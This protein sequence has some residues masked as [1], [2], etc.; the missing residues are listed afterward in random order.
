[1]EEV[2]RRSWSYGIDRTWFEV[3]WGQS[4]G[5]VCFV[6]VSWQWLSFILVGL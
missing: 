5:R 1:M 3:C 2:G 4:L 6:L